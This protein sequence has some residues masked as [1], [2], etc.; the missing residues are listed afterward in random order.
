LWVT[1]NQKKTKEIEQVCFGVCSI[2]FVC[3]LYKERIKQG[4]KVQQ[5]IQVI[6]KCLILWMS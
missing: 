3:V 2:L 5:K 4:K 1:G 6:K